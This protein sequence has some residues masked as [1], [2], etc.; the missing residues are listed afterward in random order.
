MHTHILTHAPVHPYVGDLRTY[1]TTMASPAPPA[2]NANDNTPATRVLNCFGGSTECTH[3]T[4]SATCSTTNAKNAPKCSLMST[5]LNP[6]TG[7]L[8]AVSVP[9]MMSGAKAMY[10][11]LLRRPHTMQASVKMGSRLMTKE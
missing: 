8:A 6:T 1:A 9:M 3:F 2:A 5:A 11:L 7:M 10:S 4:S